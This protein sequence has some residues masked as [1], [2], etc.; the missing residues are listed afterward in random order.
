MFIAAILTRYCGDVCQIHVSLNKPQ[1]PSELDGGSNSIQLKVQ[2]HTCRRAYGGNCYFGDRSNDDF[3]GANGF[4]G[5][6]DKAFV[7]RS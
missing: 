6:R 5:L 1:Y 4:S 7:R 3:A 2:D